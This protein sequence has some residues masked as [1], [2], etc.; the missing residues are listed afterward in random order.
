MSDLQAPK[1]SKS[2]LNRSIKQ[3]VVDLDAICLLNI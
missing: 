2:M 3:R 1:S